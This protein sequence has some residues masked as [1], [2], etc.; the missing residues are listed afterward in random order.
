MRWV[1]Y[2]QHVPKIATARAKAAVQT[3]P[4]SPRVWLQL[5]GLLG[6]TVSILLPFGLWSGFLVPDPVRDSRVVLKVRADETQVQGSLRHRYLGR[7][8]ICTVA[9]ALHSTLNRCML[10]CVHDGTGCCD[11]LLNV[12]PPTRCEC[13]YVHVAPAPPHA[14]RPPPALQGCAIAAL[15]P[16]LLEELLFRALLLPHPAVQ[17]S[18]SDARDHACMHAAQG[19]PREPPGLPWED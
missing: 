10:C 6:I 11:I 1:M 16:G 7:C 9:C 17:I 18:A 3:I 14:P 5:T 12:S 15:A 8:K 4:T 13:T 2:M 19:L